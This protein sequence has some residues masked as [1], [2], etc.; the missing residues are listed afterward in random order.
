MLN[1]TVDCTFCISHILL[2]LYSIFRLKT[3]SFPT[4]I[5]I[6]WSKT[7]LNFNLPHLFNHIIHF[8]YKPLHFVWGRDFC[9]QQNTIWLSHLFK[10][11]V[12]MGK[13]WLVFHI[14]FQSYVTHKNNNNFVDFP[15]FSYFTPLRMLALIS[16][17]RCKQNQIFNVCNSKWRGSTSLF[18]TEHMLPPR[19]NLKLQ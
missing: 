1:F 9:P 16:S 12:T 6:S 5:T 3:T 4:V 14:L 7:L 17:K 2:K 11:V 10:K 18:N 15:S 19:N 13:C 8:S